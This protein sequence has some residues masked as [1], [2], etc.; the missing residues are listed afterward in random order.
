MRAEPLCGWP[1]YGSECCIRD[2]AECDGE[3]H[4]AK[5][6]MD[7]AAR[8]RPKIVRRQKID[9]SGTRRKLNG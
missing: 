3:H 6:P 8:M 4:L 5:G 9:K 2:R 1:G 7:M